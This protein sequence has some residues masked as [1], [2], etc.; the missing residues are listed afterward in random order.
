M[1]IILS[2]Y[3][4]D[5]LKPHVYFYISFFCCPNNDAFC[6]SIAKLPP[7][8]V[9]V[10]GPFML[11][12]FSW[13]LLSTILQIIFPSLLPWMMPL[14]FSIYCIINALFRFNRA[15]TCISV[16]DLI[17]R[18]NI[19]LLCFVP[20]V[21]IYRMHPNICVGSLRF[22]CILVLRLDVSHCNLRSVLSTFPFRYLVLPIPPSVSLFPFILWGLLLFYNAGISDNFL[23][24]FLVMFI[25]LFRCD[26]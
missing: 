13:T 6:R 2:H 7:V 15:I 11:G 25:Q 9:V 16:F 14:H 12:P 8:L 3:V 18:K 21:L 10:G 5:S 4:S 22:F 1:E 26:K 19:H 17:P 24:S 20:L 23:E